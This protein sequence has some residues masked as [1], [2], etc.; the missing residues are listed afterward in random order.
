M[1]LRRLNKVKKSINPE[2][3]VWT[4]LKKSIRYLL[5]LVADRVS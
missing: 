5:V 4:A 3:R 1:F 2:L